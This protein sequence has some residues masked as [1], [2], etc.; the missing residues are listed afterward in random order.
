MQVSA[1]V[2]VDTCIEGE[3]RLLLTGSVSE[4]CEILW[5][6]ISS[7]LLENETYI[8]SFTRTGFLQF[9]D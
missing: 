3:N 7:H 2:M 8:F 1:E 4:A 5:A 9:E 6:N